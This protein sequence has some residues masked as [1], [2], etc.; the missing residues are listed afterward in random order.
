MW[1]LAQFESQLIDGVK[2]AFTKPASQIA[3]SL[4]I[5]EPPGMVGK[6]VKHF[7]KKTMRKD[8]R[9][10]SKILIRPDRISL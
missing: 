10:Q 9:T 8:Q 2:E 7:L 4:A 1:G 6:S 5:R 3:K